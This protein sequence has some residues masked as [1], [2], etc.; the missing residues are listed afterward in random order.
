[1]CPGFNREAA[2]KR[3][4]DIRDPM[5]RELRIPSLLSGSIKIF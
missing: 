1:M 3:W 4:K 5:M 2:T